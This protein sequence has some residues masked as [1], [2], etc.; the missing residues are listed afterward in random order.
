MAKEILVVDDEKAI[1]SALSVLLSGAGYEVVVVHSGEEAIEQLSVKDPDLIILDVMMPVL[2]G[3]EVCRLVRQQRE[4]IP[5]LMLTA[6]DKTWEKVT[7]LEL[8]A[9]VYMTKPFESGELSAQVKALLRLA[10]QTSP[11]FEK[12]G[13]NEDR[14]LICG[15]LILYPQQHRTLLNDKGIKLSPKEFELLHFFMQHLGQ[16]FGRQTLLRRV[17]GY[18]YPDDSRTVDTRIQRLRTKIETDPAQP[19]LL[20]TV[21][22]FGYR[23]VSAEW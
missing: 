8:G 6:K 11:H 22:G 7:G 18:D 13:N 5:I 9:D 1:T 17:W 20:Q 14:P 21:R 2:D 12:E 3:Y 15:P 19:Q 4:Y 23:L 16:V 10:E